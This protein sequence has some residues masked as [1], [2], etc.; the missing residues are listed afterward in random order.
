MLEKGNPCQLGPDNHKYLKQVLRLEQGSHVKVFDGFGHEFEA[1]IHS[2]PVNGVILELGKEIKTAAREIKI[3]LAQALPKANKMDTI[4]RA[5]AE[6]GSDVIIPFT[7]ARSVSHLSAEK[8]SLKVLRWQKIT[9][10]A[11]R[12]SRSVQVTE[13]HE[14]TS[15]ENMLDWA[16]PEALKMIF[17]EEEDLK[18]IKDVFS[19]QSTK[20][21]KD[22]FII[23][24]PE[25]GL[26]REEISRARGK[27]FISVSLGKQIL[28]VETA[29]PA[30]LSI[31]Q[32]EKGIFSKL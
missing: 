31:I 29:A 9:R 30:I 7:A 13:V 5:A 27:G 16:A 23:V 14:V 12:V 32:Y 2:F 24:G 3:T 26:T 19:D 28:K 15:F 8:G 25:G 17:W 6:L 4:V 20:K 1:V 10:E 18:S 21:T 22:I 11:A